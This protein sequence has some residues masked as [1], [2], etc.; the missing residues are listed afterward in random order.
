MHDIVYYIFTS[1]MRPSW[2]PFCFWRLF[3]I[4]AG[5]RTC[6]PIA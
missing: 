3:R 6:A 5:R 2:R 1:G 4:S